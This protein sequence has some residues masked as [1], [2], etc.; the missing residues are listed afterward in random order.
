[1]DIRP[2]VKIGAGHY[3][4]L[5]GTYDDLASLAAQLNWH[6]STT[7][8]ELSGVL[9]LTSAWD[10]NDQLVNFS[11]SLQKLVGKLVYPQGTNRQ[12]RG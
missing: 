12:T 5:K 1:M 8:G 10:F 2:R 11:T 4:R 7:F 9:P 6:G 3:C